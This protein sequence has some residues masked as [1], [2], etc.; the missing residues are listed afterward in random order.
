MHFFK[1]LSI[2]R[3]LMIVMTL[4]CMIAILILGSIVFIHRAVSEQQGIKERI[5]SL[6]EIIASRSTGA[7]SFYDRKTAT[8]NLKALNSSSNIIYAFIKDENDDI[9]AEFRRQNSNILP[10]TILPADLPLI[11]SKYL[12]LF[13]NHLIIHQAII[14]DNETIGKLFI[15]VS[16][17]QFKTDLIKY[18]LV[19]LSIMTG[20]FIFALLIASK[21]NQII[22]KPIK[23]LHQAMAAVSD[24]KDY[25]VRVSTQNEDELSALV[26]GFNR[27]LQQ[28]QHRDEKL[29]SYR[30]TLEEQVIQRSKELSDVN[31][32]R[33]QWLEIMANFLRHELKN[34]TVGIKTS[35]DL[36]EKRS[37]QGKDIEAYI[38][39][40]RKSMIFMNGLLNC[41][42]DAST[43]E[44]AIYKEPHTQIN[45]SSIIST[46][47]EEYKILYPQALIDFTCT[48]SIVMQGNQN[49]LEQM[50]DK[51]FSNAL[52]HA[53]IN[54]VIELS[55][56]KEN[57]SVKI[58]VQNE[59]VALPE[60]KD[61]IF[62]LFVS[63]RDENHKQ[64]ENFGLGLYIVRLIAE[65]HYGTVEALDLENEKGA[66]FL[67]TLPIV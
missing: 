5:H 1:R 8:E 48:D 36:I 66:R 51:L 28:I 2:A 32:Q 7:L 6:A 33:I 50:L 19:M 41:V 4:S 61:E 27:M 15:I 34:S 58:A 38:Q 59:G 21:L 31:Q 16:L 67:V 26:N 23:D 13:A 55:L 39:R 63:M 29:E 35:L 57:D 44:A 49:R 9:F 18:S 20:S 3:K 54:S 45:I 37:H 25:S 10:P 42:S 30:H 53:A 62:E 56:N 64:A 24:K 65:S 60:N 43:M 47:I 52:E 40:A 17:Q 11:P 14:L 22:S 12:D 46:R